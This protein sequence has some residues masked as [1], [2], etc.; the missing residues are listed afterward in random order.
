MCVF[1]PPLTITRDQID[2]MVAILRKSIE[3][4]MEDIEN[5]RS[6]AAGD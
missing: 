2:E 5:E 4:A 6:A 3:L 1:S